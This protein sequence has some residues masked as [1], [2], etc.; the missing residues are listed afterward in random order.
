MA[1][2]DLKT[3]ARD[4]FRRRQYDLAVEM[5]L[6]ALRFDPNDPE[7]ID[8][9]FTA[10]IKAREMKGKAIFGGMFSKVS[11]G[12]SRDPQ[13]RMQT[14]FRS[15]AKHPEDKGLL[16]ALGQ[17]AG[18]ADAGET[19]VAAYK[20]ATEID[21]DDAEAWKRLGQFHGRRGRIKEALAALDEAVRLSPRDQE[22]A[23]LRKN[24]AA[25]GAL[26]AG[27]YDKAGSSR[28]LMKDQDGARRLEAEDR[29][30]LTKEH[31]ATEVDAM[32][33]RIAENPEDSRL[34]VRLAD[35]YLHQNHEEEALAALEKAAS[36][37]AENYD[38]KVRVGDMKIRR[39]QAAARDAKAAAEAAAG[40]EGLKEA[41]KAAM[42]TFL[43]AQRKE[44]A[45]RVDAHPLDLTERF[46]LGRTLLALN[47]VDAAAAEF[48]QTVRDPKRKTESLLL[49]AQCFEKK[50]LVGLA[51]KKLE[52]A[53]RDFP[54]LSSPQSKDAYYL[55]G[56]LLER[57]GEREQARKVFEQIFEVDITYRDVS[58]RLEA[59]TGG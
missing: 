56:A 55:Y 22:S 58:Q 12:K 53:I 26:Q 39:M 18:D 34:Y 10:A 16:L 4:A 36:L 9:F 14:C 1:V 11:L 21:A 57:S 38:L 13:K 51:V 44:Y 7:T 17:A 6:E 15:L 24:L 25:E 3:K 8:G 54:A 47:E 27:R 29:R 59:L 49:L 23:K 5:Y 30:Q 41:A 32:E 42:E 20:R 19:A 50:N 28:E 35:L 52:E 43:Q 40:D 33:M 45:K 46:R 2:S 37:D 48:Q 31:A